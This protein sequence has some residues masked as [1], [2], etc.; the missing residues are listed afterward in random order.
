MLKFLRENVLQAA[1]ECVNAGNA[2]PRVTQCPGKTVC[3]HLR[4]HPREEW[5]YS[6]AHG[7]GEDREAWADGWVEMRVDVFS[8]I[9]SG[10][11]GASP[12]LPT[13]LVH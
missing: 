4:G 1:G 3:W 12:R 13:L 11:A 5:L 2:S 6:R 8:V 10:Q 7:S 9:V